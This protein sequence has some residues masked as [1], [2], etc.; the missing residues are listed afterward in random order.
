MEL[1]PR[2]EGTVRARQLSSLPLALGGL[3][4]RSAIRSQHA[5]YWASWA[6]SLPR[7]RERHPDI[8]DVIGFPCSEGDSL[9]KAVSKPQQCA[10]N[11]FWMWGSTPQSGGMLPEVRGQEG[12]RRTETPLN[13]VLGGNAW[14]AKTSRRPT[15]T[16]LCGR[17][18]LKQ[19]EHYSGPSV[20]HLQAFRSLAHQ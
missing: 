9:M 14:P 4:L 15:F 3:G 19:T 12:H 18:S 7:I 17:S 10:E 11:D 1:H 5:A 13:P 20:V 8:A 2:V 16:V 6:D